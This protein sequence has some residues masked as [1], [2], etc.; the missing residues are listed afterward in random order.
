VLVVAARRVGE[1][2]QQR[3]MSSRRRWLAIMGGVVQ[4]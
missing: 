3:W 2:Q 4:Q 1:A